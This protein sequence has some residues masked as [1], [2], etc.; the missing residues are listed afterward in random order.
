MKLAIKIRN[1]KLVK[2]VRIIME[3]EMQIKHREKLELKKIA[4]I[5][6]HLRRTL[7]LF[8]YSVLIHD[9][10]HIIKTIYKAIKSLHK[11]IKSFGLKTKFQS[12]F[13]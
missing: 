3:T 8:L 13:Y 9:I 7:G 5:S 6:I 11:K 12:Q 1:W 10:H 4:S 2:I